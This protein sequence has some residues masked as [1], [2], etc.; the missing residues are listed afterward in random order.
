M[1]QHWYP[2]WLDRWN[3]RGWE[4]RAWWAP[5]PL[6]QW[7]TPE[8]GGAAVSGMMTVQVQVSQVRWNRLMDGS[9]REARREHRAAHS[10]VSSGSLDSELDEVS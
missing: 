1:P 8:V 5:C 4:L 6:W 9:P 3:P 10:R 2:Y 7:G